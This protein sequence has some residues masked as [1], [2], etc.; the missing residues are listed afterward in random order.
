MLFLL[1]YA[2]CTSA[3]TS[4]EYATS[5]ENWFPFRYIKEGDNIN[6]GIFPEMLTL[7]FEQE[8]GLALNY[9][10]LPWK[11]AQLEVEIGHSDFILTIPTNRGALIVQ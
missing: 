3:Q 4:I 10:L 7:L 2:V 5:D 1:S 8:L 11:R 9:K 6:R